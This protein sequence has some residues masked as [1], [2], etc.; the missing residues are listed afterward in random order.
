M[1]IVIDEYVLDATFYKI[2]L[3]DGSEVWW[4]PCVLRGDMVQGDQ[5]YLIVFSDGE[6]HHTYMHPLQFLKQ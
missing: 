6:H 2:E 1:K 3:E 5:G 4:R